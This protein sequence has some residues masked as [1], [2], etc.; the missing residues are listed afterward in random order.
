MDV[1]PGI[2][3]GWNIDVQQDEVVVGEDRDVERSLVHGHRL[4]LELGKCR[5]RQRAAK[6]E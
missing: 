1:V 3:A 2:T 6:R 4:V 5:L